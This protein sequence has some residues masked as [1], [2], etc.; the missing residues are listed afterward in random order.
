MTNG[1]KIV[2][3]GL[4][5]AATAGCLTTQPPVVPA[6]PRQVSS[7][8]VCC[9][10][11]TIARDVSRL[12]R[13]DVRNWHGLAVHLSQSTDSLS[14]FLHAQLDEVDTKITRKFFHTPHYKAK[15][16]SQL[17]EKLSAIV[18]GPSIYE[19]QRFAHVT[20]RPCT[21]A[22]ATGNPTGDELR[23]LNHL[24]LE[25]AY[26]AFFTRKACMD[27]RSPDDPWP[28]SVN[29]QPVAKEF[30]LRP[31]AIEYH[32]TPH[33]ACMNWVVIRFHDDNVPAD[34]FSILISCDTNKRLQEAI[35]AANGE[36]AVC[37]TGIDPVSTRETQNSLRNLPPIK[38]RR[39]VGTL[40]IPDLHKYSL[41]I[42]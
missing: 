12:D 21:K 17:H 30:R 25:D 2:V 28:V 42:P 6:P 5:C 38:G 27:C 8:P 19:P 34:Y 11:G 3:L 37:A 29:G 26:P 10:N 13:I 40:M 18:D 33:R 15:L 31:T 7:Q 39:L 1:K 23:R 24:L 22:L 36:I 20:L 41:D 35:G 4:I 14:V 16:L 32:Q 9:P